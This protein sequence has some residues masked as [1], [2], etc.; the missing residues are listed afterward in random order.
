M[1]ELDKPINSYKDLQ[2]FTLAI[3]NAMGEIS[4]EE[5]MNG[6]NNAFHEYEQNTVSRVSDLMTTIINRDKGSNG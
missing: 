4:K 6:I 3:I 2:L 1:D 5:A